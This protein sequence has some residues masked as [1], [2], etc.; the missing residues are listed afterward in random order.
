MKM[1]MKNEKAQ[2]DAEEIVIELEGCGIGVIL[3]ERAASY[4]ARKA[5]RKSTNVLDLIRI[6]PYILIDVPGFSLDRADKV[7]YKLGV[8]TDDDRRT[9]AVIKIVLRT[10]T[11][12]GHT[13]LPYAQLKKKS[14][15]AGVFEED[16]DG[17][18]QNM[19]ELD[20]IVCET[21]VDINVDADSSMTAHSDS[22]IYLRHFFDAEVQ[23]AALLNERRN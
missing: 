3:A 1:K 18:L 10:N 8:S 16:L 11:T 5:T 19:I 9:A 7:A 21:D 2:A 4:F 12:S 23:A 6:D 22:R 14:K 17:V 13:Y 20:A 15:K